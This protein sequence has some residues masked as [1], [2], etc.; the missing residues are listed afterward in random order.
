MSL[1]RQIY[2]SEL[3]YLYAKREIVNLQALLTPTAAELAALD[4]WQ[5]KVT[6]DE[7]LRLKWLD[8]L[9]ALGELTDDAALRF[10]VLNE[11]DAKEMAAADAAEQRLDGEEDSER[12][13]A[14]AVDI[15]ECEN[16]R[17]LIAELRE[18][19]PWPP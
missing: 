16:R 3:D 2:V 1:L 9:A 7:L 14:L 6:H 4:Y 8:D 5:D 13:T 12:A 10:E 15:G 19:S 17:I 11:Q 18:T